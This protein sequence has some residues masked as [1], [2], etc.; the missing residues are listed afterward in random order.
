MKNKNL[1]FNFHHL[2]KYLQFYSKFK[3]NFYTKGTQCIEKVPSLIPHRL[4][5]IEIVTTF[6]GN[7]FRILLPI[8][9]MSVHLEKHFLNVPTALLWSSGVT[10]AS[11]SSINNCHCPFIFILQLKNKTYSGSANMISVMV[12]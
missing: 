10:F 7:L 4:Y 9:G 11:L 6:E 5:S 3:R 2:F 1:D 8:L 12:D